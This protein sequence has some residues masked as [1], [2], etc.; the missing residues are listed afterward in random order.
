MKKKISM[1]LAVSL[2]ATNVSPALNVFADEIYNESSSSIEES[3]VNEAKV[4]LF[5]LRNYSNFE[6]YNNTYKV[7]NNEI[8]S[9]SNNGGQYASSSIDKAI[10]GELSTHW[11]TGK[12]NTS[13]FKNEVVVEFENTEAINR[14]AYATRQ[15]TARGKGFPTEFEVYSSLSGEDEDFSL[16]CTGSY[17]TTGDMIE[18]KFDTTTA[19]KIKFVFKEANQGWASASELWFYREDSLLDKMNNIFTDESKNKVSSDFDT[20]EKLEAFEEELSIHPFYEEIKED[21]KNAKILLENKEYAY[22]D[23]KVS[24]F[25]SLDDER[26]EAYDELFKISRESITK[27]ETN[28]GQYSSNSIEK[29]IDNNIN[30]GW[31]SGKQNSSSHTNEVIITLNEL[32]TINRVMYTNINSRGFSQEF[33]IY[34]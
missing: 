9:I 21:I 24:K 12:Q 15:D 13:S 27:I 5:K 1:L 10:D 34:A 25:I 30:T 33:E 14:I 3:L 26:L 22:I 8:L 7:K 19:K 16:V 31:H 28:G 32:T 2:I 17:S 23:A 18:I 6:N 20:L 29:A 11:E 4:S